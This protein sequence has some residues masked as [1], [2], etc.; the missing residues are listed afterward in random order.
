MKQTIFLIAIALLTP[1]LLMAHGSED[2]L[3]ST[4]KIYSV[5][6]AVVIIFLGIVI[7]LVRIDRKV[8][9]LEKEMRD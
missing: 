8:S 7:Y 4:G 2:F 9:R 1:V 6:L 3:R 5:V